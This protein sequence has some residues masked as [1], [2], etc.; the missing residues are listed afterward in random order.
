MIQKII[1]VSNDIL[2]S[3]DLSEYKNRRNENKLPEH[4]FFMESG[5]EHYRL[6]C[7]ISTLY[8]DITFIDIGTWVGSSAL[9]LGFNKNNK[10][11]SFDIVRQ[12]RDTQGI[13]VDVDGVIKDDNIKFEIGNVLEYNK[14]I[15]L[16][17][18]FMM[19]DTKHDGVF[20]KEFYDFLISEK[21]KGI[22]LFDD[23]HL[24][25]HMKNFWSNIELEKY[26]ITNIGHWS[27]T[28]VVVF[29]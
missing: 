28:G 26:D 17:S 15:I 22:V 4:W 13:M 5:K 27:G 21:Y 8:N 18:P 29:K 19:L 16:S 24:N 10:V 12:K 14:E 7:Y 23:I 1:E 2:N 25:T 11:I 20:E 3:I 9:A 6:L